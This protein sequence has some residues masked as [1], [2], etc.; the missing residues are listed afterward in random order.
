M[1]KKVLYGF[2]MAL[3][4]SASMGTLQS[5]KD[6][7]SDFKHQYNYDQDSLLKRLSAL[8]GAVQACKENCRQEIDALSRRIQTNA[9]KIDNLDAELRNLAAKLSDYV[10]YT[11]LET[12]LA[13]LET[14]LETNCNAYTDQ[15]IA[16][17]LAPIITDLNNVKTDLGDL[18]GVVN[19]LKEDFSKLSDKVDANEAAIIAMNTTLENHETAL[20]ELNYKLQELEATVL[21]HTE[22]IEGLKLEIEGLNNMIEEAFLKIEETQQFL[23]QAINMLMNEIEEKFGE[24]T[25]RLD[26][27]ITG[28]VLQGTDSPVFGNLNTPLGIQSNILF[29]WYGYNDNPGFKF[30]SASSMYNYYDA[31]PVLTDSDLAALAPEYQDVKRGIYGDVNLGKLYMTINPA[32]HF[33]NEEGF[34]LESTAENQYPATLK[35]KKSTEELT[36]GYTRATVEGNG[37]Y[38]A[39]VIV[40]AAN[41]EAARMDL[42]DGLKSSMENAL[43]DPSK[44]TAAALLKGVYSQLNGT[45]PAYAVRYNWSNNDKDYSVVSNYAVAATTAKPLS[46]SFLYGKGTDKKLPT[47]GHIDNFIYKLKDNANFKFDFTGYGLD[48]E[49]FSIKIDP[50]EIN[51]DNVK[52]TGGELTVNLPPI[53]VYGNVEGVNKGQLIGEAHPDP[54]VVEGNDLNNIYAAIEKGIKDA[55]KDMS[56]DITGWTNDLQGQINTKVDNMLSDVEVK[57]NKMLKDIGDDITGRVENIIDEFGDQAEPYFKRINRLID[58]YNKVAGKINGFLSNPNHYLQVAMFYNQANSNMGLLSNAKSSP[59]VFTRG[60][61]NFCLYASSYTGELVCPA[62]MKYVAVTNVYDAKTGAVAANAAAERT[63]V[64][65][66]AEYFNTVKSGNTIRYAV[67]ASALKSG[68]I[69]EIVYQ[70]VDYSG[71]TSTQ[72]FYIQVK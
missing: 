44:R 67:P 70:G 3:V 61:G 33:F 5:C 50:L 2:A 25:N 29:N 8:E 62:Y 58:L 51:A 26:N 7:M 31:E 14:K 9:D 59:T 22:E 64:N 39:D 54:V 38:E 30:P 15:Q 6:D 41:I 13:E 45:L 21:G 32:G 40:E 43:K 60:N 57:I 28:I 1:K 10:T 46:Y 36:F 66:A 48:F 34:K 56:G 63:A 72:K 24:L 18:S 69:Y 42:Q 71:R 53:Y 52:V 16:N 11:D 19:G 37:F 17:A 47:F 12:K 4:A 68:L 27:L 55:I 35:V 20:R 49:P 65:N 23:T